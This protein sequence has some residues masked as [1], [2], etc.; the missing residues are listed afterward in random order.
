MIDARVDSGF[1]RVR[2]AA[3]DHPKAAAV[4]RKATQTADSATEAGQFGVSRQGRQGGGPRQTQLGI[5]H[6]AGQLEKEK[7]G[8]ATQKLL[9]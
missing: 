3:H 8:H 4:A 9:S 5:R 2:L 7:L 6:L 1:L